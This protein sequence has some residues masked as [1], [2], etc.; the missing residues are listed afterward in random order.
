MFPRSFPMMRSRFDRLLLLLPGWLAFMVYLP[1]LGNGFV[2]D[3]NYFLTDMPYLRDPAL[4]WQH[5][6][7]PLFVSRNYFRPLPLLTFVLEIRLGG[8]NPFVFHLSN[9]LLHVLNTTLVVLLARG[10]SN[11]AANSSRKNVMAACAGLLFGLHP[12]LIETVCWISDRFDLMMVFFLFSALLCDLT[13]RHLK[14]RALSV[15]VLFLLALLCKETAVVFA[16]LLP[17]WQLTCRAKRGKPLREGAQQLVLDGTVWTWVALA[18]AG[19]VYLALRYEALGVF[20]RADALIVPGSAV[21]HGLLTAKTLAWYVLLLFWPFGQTGPVH[22]GVT[23]IPMSD[24]WAWLNVGV[25]LMVI[26]GVAAL[27]RRLP[28][29]GLLV[30][31]ALLALAPVAN[32]VPL[33]IGD[34]M[35]HDRYLILPLAFLALALAIMPPVRSAVVAAVAGGL[36]AA[37]C[38]TAIIFTVPRW[39]TNLSL[40]GWA[41]AMEPESN[42]AR[43]NYVAALVN[44]S[45]NQATL[46]LAHEILL[47]EPNN[48]VAMHDMGLALMRLG[49]DEEARRY[50]EMALKHLD[51]TDAKGRLD[52]SEAWNLLG[53]LSLRSGDWDSAEKSLN[54]A[55][56]ITPYLTR[57][58]FNLAMLHYERGN[59]AEGDRELAFA[60]RYDAPEMIPI[61]RAQ[62]DRKKAEVL[63][64]RGSATSA[65]PSRQ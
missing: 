50:T 44:A 34:N 54:E 26:L 15:G 47:R 30:C 8:L 55:I 6:L 24:A 60:L 25:V 58:H 33:T 48:A 3:D 65:L 64:R 36:W 17:V 28:Q 62:A 56:R 23:P 42:I 59:M 52:L 22:P 9:L 11:S 46:D 39:E 57:P 13:I 38:V 32:L 2:W 37:L 29:M 16:V 49:R 7:E 61:H 21:Q 4:W 51:Q 53:Y 35:V 18:L 41:Y 1:A 10:L 45:H 12:A 63:A 19:L 27:V 43:G 40:W 31:A 5:I 14:A 20:Y